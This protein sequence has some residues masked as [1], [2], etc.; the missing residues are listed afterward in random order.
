VITSDSL[1]APYIPPHNI[2]FLELI[3]RAMLRV[4]LPYEHEMVVNI[5]K[6]QISEAKA[7]DY[8]KRSRFA[9]IH[10][11]LTP[12]VTSSKAPTLSHLS[13]LHLPLFSYNF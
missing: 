1:P 8:T 12:D 5:L 6:H 11:F 10:Y 9:I 4:C 2:T 3:L 7:K 13:P